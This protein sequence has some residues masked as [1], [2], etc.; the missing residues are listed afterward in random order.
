MV[1]RGAIFDLDGTLV[2][3]N[4]LHT[5]AWQETFRHF[6]KE[7]PYEKLRHQIG[8]GGDQYLPEFLTEAELREIRP[9]VE[10]FRG[11][12]FKKEYLGRAK[13]F[14]K[15]RE[16][17]ERLRSDGKRIA[18]ASSGNEE[19]ISHYVKL[20][21]VGDLIETQTTKSDVE[22]SK[23]RPDVFTVALNLLQLQPQDA[24]VVGDTPYDVIAAKKIE[25]RTIALLCGGFLE[26]ELRATGAIA[27]FRDPADL[28][29]HYARSAL[30]G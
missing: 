14:P 12:L 1:V 5:E 16:L 22:H 27:L 15:V 10:K 4:D 23:P 17:F 29:E 11:E 9:A 25:L 3:S 6:G 28:L 26:D 24:I 7:I 8:K 18:L 2:D 20:L 19:E 30:I 21:D 13:P